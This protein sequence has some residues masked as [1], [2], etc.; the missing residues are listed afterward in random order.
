MDYSDF[1]GSGI[2]A[3]LG[4]VLAQVINVARLVWTSWTRPRLAIELPHDNC[5]ILSHGAEVGRGEIYDEKIFGFYVR[6]VGR[7]I[8][9]GVRFQLVKIEYREKEW[10]EFAD[11]SDQAYVLSLYKGAGRKSEDI[12]TV[13]VPGAAALVE[14]AGW[15]EDHGAIFPAVSGLPDYYE[16]LHRR[17]SVP[18]H[19]RSI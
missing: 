16:D 5:E 1:I 9:T 13:L 8:A 7:R 10:P 19:C 17:D 2:G 4:F 18:V 12:E 15:R 6:N 3:V 14:L 11:I